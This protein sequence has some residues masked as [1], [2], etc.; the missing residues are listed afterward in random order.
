M[1]IVDKIIFALDHAFYLNIAKAPAGM[2]WAYWKWRC[3]GAVDAVAWVVATGR[4]TCT[5]EKAIAG[6]S[7]YYLVRHIARTADGNSTDDM[8]AAM[9]KFSGLVKRIGAGEQIPRHR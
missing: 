5:E 3:Q 1:T 8:I 6:C 2:D 7:A 4:V 9:W